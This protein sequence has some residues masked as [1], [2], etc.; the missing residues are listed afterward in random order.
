MER[1]SKL[2]IY[3]PFPVVIGG[4]D[5]RGVG[6]KAATVIDN[7]SAS[8]LYVRLARSLGTGTEL[9]F[10]IQLSILGTPEEFS[11]ASGRM[12]WWCAPS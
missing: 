8:G 4:V 9:A 2:R 12:A 1:R 10:T 7:L 11:R 3:D 6:F 5:A